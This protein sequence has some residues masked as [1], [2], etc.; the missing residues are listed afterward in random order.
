MKYP[1]T[2]FL[3]VLIC[4]NIVSISFAQTGCTPIYGGGVKSDNLPYCMEGII[5]PTPTSTSNAQTPSFITPSTNTG[6]TKSGY[7]VQSPSYAQQTPGTGPSETALLA[8]I[9]FAVTG[10]Y[11]RKK[12]SVL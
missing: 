5:Q 10:L 12:T 7:R 11:L 6:Q 9:L 4:I 3:S 2:L 1:I 8:C